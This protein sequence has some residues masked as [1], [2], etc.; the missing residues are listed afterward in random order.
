MQVHKPPKSRRSADFALNFTDFGPRPT[1]NGSAWVLRD[2]R[3]SGGVFAS[4]K[5]RA[6]T[7]NSPRGAIAVSVA[8][9]R[10]FLRLQKPDALPQ[11]MYGDAGKNKRSVLV[12]SVGHRRHVWWH[13]SGAARGRSRASTRQ[14]CPFDPARG[15]PSFCLPGAAL[16]ETLK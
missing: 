4:K 14:C 7:F 12:V 13:R 1:K 15:R 2:S 6:T 5:F 8:R 9:C 3:C 10:L 11:I 16:G